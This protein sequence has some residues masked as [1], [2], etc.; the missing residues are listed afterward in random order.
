MTMRTRLITRNAIIDI[1]CFLHILL[2]VYAAANK[3]L[4]YDTF[5]VQLGQ[6]PLLS[7]YAEWMAWA[8]P[9]A[10]LGIAALLS[11]KRFRFAGL[12]ASFTLMVMF[13]AYI[14]ILLHYSTFVPCSCGGILEKLSWEEHLVFNAAF[15]LLALTGVVLLDSYSFRRRLL[16]TTGMGIAGILLVATLY[17]VSEN[18]QHYHNR[19][20]RRLSK[21]PVTKLRE[22]DLKLNSYYFAG[23]DNMHVY[24]GNVTAP[25]VVTTLDSGLA[26]L[27]TN[28]I[29]LSRKDLPFRGVSVEVRPPYFFVADGSV[30]C[31]FRGRVSDWQAKLQKSDRQFFS[32]AEPMDSLAVAVR[33]QKPVTGKSEL[34]TMNILSGGANVNPKLLETHGDALFDTDGTLLYSSGMKRIIYVYAYRNG[35]AMADKSLS[36]YPS[37]KTIDT[38][39]H[40]NV[41]VTE[42]MERNE[43]KLARRPLVVNRLAA[44]YDN[45]LFVN[46][47][48]PGKYESNQ[49]WKMASIVD[50]YNLSDGSYAESF[51]IYDVDGK[52]LKSFV[53]EGNRL[54]ALIGN[55]ILSYRLNGAIT[56]HYI[57]AAER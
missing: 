43:K 2:F 56:K 24:L 21:A 57:H 51:Y 36:P 48:I 54:Y 9:L 10:E 30:P 32:L 34:G 8:V 22:A 4:D 28:R 18:I 7:A 35:Y 15:V 40:A 42:I 1:V 49:M 29:N 20:V 45:L 19:F 50:V 12:L 14:Y 37:G 13:T 26:N 52:K 25:L 27:G 33:F 53:V 5:R 16:L 23:T 44:V 41:E 46:S 38:I 39:T 11:V 3:L 47:G 31:V 6:S 17:D 55:H